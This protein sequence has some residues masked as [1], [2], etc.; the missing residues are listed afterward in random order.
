MDKSPVLK[1]VY[2]SIF[3]DFLLRSECILQDRNKYILKSFGWT[4]FGQGRRAADD[5]L[6]GDM[7]R[8][9]CRMLSDWFG[10]GLYAWFGLLFFPGGKRFGKCGKGHEFGSSGIHELAAFRCP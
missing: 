4:T 3:L 6:Y 1:L 8:R 2:V 5:S 10:S 7:L 9:V